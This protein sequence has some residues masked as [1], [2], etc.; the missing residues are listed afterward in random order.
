M[1]EILSK[2]PEELDCFFDANVCAPSFAELNELAKV[3]AVELRVVIVKDNGIVKACL[4]CFI[5]NRRHHGLTVKIYSSYSGYLHDYQRYLCL[6][7]VYAK[8]LRTAIIN[9]ARHCSCD[10]VCIDSLL[11]GKVAPRGFNL[12]SEVKIFDSTKSKNGW[13][14]LYIRKS[15]KRFE[16]DARKV[17]GYHVEIIDGYVEDELMRELKRL[18]ILRWHFSGSSSAFESRNNRIEQYRCHPENKHYLRILL[19]NEILACHYGMKYGNTLLWHTPLINPK[20]LR[21]S[22]LRLL[23]AEEAKYCEANGF[24][25][26]DFG[27]GEEAYKDGYC[28]DIRQTLNFEYPLSF[29]GRISMI[30]GVFL[31]PVIKQMISKLLNVARRVKNRVHAIKVHWVYFI[32]P[33]DKEYYIDPL[34]VEAHNWHEMYDLAVQRNFQIHEWQY[35]RF[36]NDDSCKFVALADERSILTYGWITDKNR[37]LIGRKDLTQR[38]LFDFVTPDI[39]RNRGY[40]TRLLK[41]LISNGGGIIYA[42]FRNIPSLRAIE[43]AGFIKV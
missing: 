6:S 19:N 16:H 39:Y 1:I 30:V 22:P 26:I 15:V 34:F 33:C 7:S 31:R 43:K 13:K 25:K 40:Y 20:Y 38:I 5:D 35:H 17:G 21:L 42:D 28:H 4:P 36:K 29:K 9:D 3:D 2:I 18:H 11:P 41:H 32:A 37:S 8:E 14:E 23:L 24:E 27:L 10:I 12:K